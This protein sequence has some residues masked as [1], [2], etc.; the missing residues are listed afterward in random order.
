MFCQF[1][2]ATVPPNV[3][4]CPNCGKE[5]PPSSVAPQPV[6]P[7]VYQPKANIEVQTGAWISRGWEVVQPNLGAFALMALL[8]AVLSS[9]VP[10]I[11]QGSLMAGMHIAAM[12]YLMFKRTDVGDLFK[13][14]NYFLPTMIAG[15]LISVF[16]FLGTLLCI[17][18]G[19]V[20]AAMYK[21]TFLF[22][23]DKR[24]DFWPAMQA[25]HNVVK[26]NYFGFTIF[27]LA[28]V[29]LNIAGALCCF[30]GLLVTL[31]ISY[32]AITV[33]YQDVVGF[34]PHADI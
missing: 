6:V 14:F 15:L 17:I 31:P 30:V 2:G 32:A 34:E 18:P 1:C 7:Q 26:G 29:L 19:L 5:Q 25:S 11:L 22:I 3:T 23:V 9:V 27:L 12:R 33:A 24:M 28:L 8:F 13:G 20:V 21:F 16:V 10:F 4:F